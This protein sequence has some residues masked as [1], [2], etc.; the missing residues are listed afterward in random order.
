MYHDF[1]TGIVVLKCF[2]MAAIFYFCLDIISSTA[3]SKS[4][5]GTRK[6]FSQ[7][8]MHYRARLDTINLYEKPQN[9]ASSTQSSN[10]QKIVFK[11][12]VVASVGVSQ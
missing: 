5:E 11:V 3:G 1:M 7:F 2:T 8:A 4:Y 9:D 10:I 12:L 6:C